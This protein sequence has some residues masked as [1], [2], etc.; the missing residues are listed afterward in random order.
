MMGVVRAVQRRLEAAA[1]ERVRADSPAA[2]AAAASLAATSDAEA[3][4]ILAEWWALPDELMLRFADGWASNG[5]AMGYVDA[6]LKR[7]GWEEG[8]PEPPRDPALP[9]C[10]QDT[11]GGAAAFAMSRRR[12]MR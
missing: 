7:V 6:W 4:V 9:R 11:S 1:W 3:E 5:P 2:A 10:C 8:P 12:A